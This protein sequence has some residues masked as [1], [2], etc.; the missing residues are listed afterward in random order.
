MVGIVAFLVIRQV[1]VPKSFGAYGYYRGDN[2]LEW[3]GKVTSYSLTSN[4]Q[5]CHQ[6]N[7]DLWVNSV[8]ASVSCE[9]CHG[10]GE[11]HI[12]KGQPMTVNPDESLCLTCHAKTE[13][14]PQNFP[15]VDESHS[16]GI[17]CVGCHN[18]HSPLKGIK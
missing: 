10:A 5:T 3:A 17:Q 6:A 1:F 2:V 14:R 12:Q 18:P 15:Q 4:C 11:S 13:G 7:Y 16:Q 9:N 8:H